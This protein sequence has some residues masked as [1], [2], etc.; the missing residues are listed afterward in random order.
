MEFYPGGLILAS[1]SR[2]RRALLA[3]LQLPFHCEAPAVDETPL[4]G[5]SGS[6]LASRLARAKAQ[7]VAARFPQ[8]LVIGSDQV[9]A[10]GARLLGKPLDHARATEQLRSCSGK[11]VTFH[12]ALTLA[13]QSRAL[14]LEHVEMV[15][16]LFRELSEAQIERYLRREEPYDCAGSFKCEGLGIALFKR[17]DS[18]DPTALE[19]LPLI[20]LSG[21]LGEAGVPV[22]GGGE[23]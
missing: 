8:A 11:T 6:A 12:T 14:Q 22:L 23:N 4:A 9:A 5:E 18:H 7:E 13:C 15:Q 10:C 1:T 16:V 21:L 19:G 2:Y 17:I 20:A 3:R